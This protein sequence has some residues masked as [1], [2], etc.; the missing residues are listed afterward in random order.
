[1]RDENDEP[2]YSYNDKYMRWF[3]RQSIKGGRVC[4]FNQ[5][6]RSKNCYEVSEILSEELNVKGNVY[7]IIEAYMKYKKYHEEIIEKVYES[8]FNDNRDIDEEEM[9]NYIFKKLGELTI[10]KLLQELSLNELLWDFDSVSFYPSAL[11][12][13][14]AIYPRIE[15]GYAFTP[16]MIEDL[17]NKF[18]NQAFIQG[19]AIL[20]IKYYN[21]QNLIVQHLPVKERVKKWKF[22]LWEMVILL[23]L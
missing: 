1:M 16:D 6:Y 4:A 11:S 14:K 18:N 22:I 15:T 5:Y 2:I 23:I 20:K 3:V 17:V 8:K 9:D 19:S 12:D 13:P 21:P 10:H 7:D